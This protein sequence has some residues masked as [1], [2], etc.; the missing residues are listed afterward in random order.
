M[1][2]SRENNMEKQTISSIPFS[3]ENGIEGC[4]TGLRRRQHK[5]KS[6]CNSQIK[7]AEEEKIMCFQKRTA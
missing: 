4:I 5:R 3:G 1:R 6:V 2:L 7:T